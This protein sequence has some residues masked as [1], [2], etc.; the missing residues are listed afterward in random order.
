MKLL[1]T[2][3][4]GATT[5]KLSVLHTILVAHINCLQ[6]EYT[7]LMVKGQFD[8]ET[9]SLYKCLERNSNQFTPESLDNQKTAAEISAAKSR[10]K[11]EPNFRRDSYRG[12]GYFSRR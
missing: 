1:S 10:M 6:S 2:F 8:K 12:R 9:A 3:D 7:E 11:P 4:E 5:E